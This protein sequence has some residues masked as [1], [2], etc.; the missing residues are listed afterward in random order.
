[1]NKDVKDHVAILRLRKSLFT[2][3]FRGPRAGHCA[4]TYLPYNGYMQEPEPFPLPRQFT[5]RFVIGR[6]FLLIPVF[7]VILSLC[8][9]A[10]RQAFPV[11]FAGYATVLLATAPVVVRA[12][13]R[14][15]RYLEIAGREAADEKLR[16]ESP[17]H[18]LLMLGIATAI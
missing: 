1:M 8:L 18:W 2:R 5:A 16:C 6:L 11:M 17:L 4:E 12:A 10:T 13:K 14:Q 15:R 7:A 9:V 3:S